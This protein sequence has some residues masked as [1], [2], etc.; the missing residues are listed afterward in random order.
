[1]SEVSSVGEYMTYVDVMCVL[2]LYNDYLEIITRNM[3]K[4]RLLKKD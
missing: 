1:M 4:K 3:E 2:T